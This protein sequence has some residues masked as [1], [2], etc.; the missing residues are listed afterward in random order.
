MRYESFLYS[1]RLRELEEQADRN[2]ISYLTLMENAGSRAADFL[3]NKGV[4]N[5]ESIV[6]ILCGAGNNGGDGYKMATCFAKAFPDNTVSVIRFGEPQTAIA[7]E[8]YR[9]ASQLP[10]VRIIPS[11]QYT[12]EQYA[13]VMP[14]KDVEEECERFVAV[15]A[16]YGIGFHGSLPEE[17]TRV[18]K[19]VRKRSK[20]TIVAVD[21]PSG[22]QADEDAFDPQ[23]LVP[24]YTLTFTMQ[25]RCMQYERC[26]FV[27]G[28][29]RVFDVGIPQDLVHTYAVHVY[30]ILCD[31]VPAGLTFRRSDSHKGTYGTVFSLTGSFGMAGASMLSGK[32]A[33]RLGVGLVHMFLP[34][35]IYPIVAGQLWEAVYHPLEETKDGGLAFSAVQ[36]ITGA[37]NGASSAAF[38]CGPGLSRNKHTAAMIRKLLPKLRVPQILDAD[39]LNAYIGHID[40]WK[41]MS[42]SGIP[43]VLTPHPKEAARLLGCSVEEVERDRFASAI[44]LSKQTG[45]TVVLK[46]AHTLVADPC[47]RVYI[48]TVPCSGLAKGGSGDVL[49]GMIASLVAQGTDPYRASVT[50]VHLHSLAAVRT[51]QRLSET[52]MLPTDLLGELPMLLS[53]F[54]KRG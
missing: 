8:M 46:G 12:S 17:V 18:F 36:Q 20:G 30:P 21:I 13:D 52:G 7:Q 41:A 5:A 54:E 15:D 2:G 6:L 47:E 51:A 28:D 24:S 34:A 11:E 49:A 9:Q 31:T 25:K 35:S 29:I 39:G 32:A 26:A 38:L 37:V 16:V 4:V 14:D 1:R 23:L 27:C 42:D 33:M 19:D 45:A 48:N 3:I 50:A 40:E 53:Q 10:N 43:L 44:R 22:M